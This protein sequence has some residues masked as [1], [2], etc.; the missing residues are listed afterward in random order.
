MLF[1]RLNVKQLV[2]KLMLLQIMLVAAAGSQLHRR[3]RYVLRPGDSFDLN[4]RLTPELNQTVIVQPDG[5]VNLNLVG[6]M[7]VDGMSIDQVHDRILEKASSRLN[8]PELNIILKEFNKPYIVVSGEVER[9][10]KIEIREN[11]TAFQAIMLA[12]GFKASGY[13]TNVYLFRKVNEDNAEV[14]KLNLHNI[15]KTGDLER[16]ITL[17]PGDMLLVPRNKLE[18]FSRIMK[19]TNLGLYFD[20]T[21]LKP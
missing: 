2:A 20:P 13:E 3:E 10:G 8:H 9:P 7:K 12:G 14:R 17:Q 6:D 19:A 4:Y 11:I 5:Y 18:K 16:D 1:T 15:Q 21:S